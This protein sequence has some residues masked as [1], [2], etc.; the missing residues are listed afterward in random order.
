MN[1]VKNIFGFGRWIEMRLFTCFFSLLLPFQNF[2]EPVAK[3]HD[4]NTFP[5]EYYSEGK[6]RTGTGCCS[7]C[8]SFHWQ[9]HKYVDLMSDC[10]SL[11]SDN[12][13]SLFI[14]RPPSQP[15]QTLSKRQT[16]QRWHL[17]THT[18]TVFTLVSVEHWM[19]NFFSAT[20]RCFVQI[21]PIDFATVDR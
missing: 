13:C 2:N 9:F 6:K 11:H 16:K 1:V 4:T 20:A 14:E 8:L 21:T 5:N 18:Q 12:L 3:I 19:N 10:Q 17:R 15:L 7:G